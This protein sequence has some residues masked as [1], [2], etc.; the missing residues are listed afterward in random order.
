VIAGHEACPEAAGLDRRASRW[1][2]CRWVM[3]A[4]RMSPKSPAL[5]LAFRAVKPDL[6]INVCCATSDLLEALVPRPPSW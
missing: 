6:R 3:S 2:A 4:A 5:D 1:R